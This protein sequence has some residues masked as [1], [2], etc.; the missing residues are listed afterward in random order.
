MTLLAWILVGAALVALLL[1]GLGIV[2]TLR[3]TRRAPFRLPDAELP[4]ISLLK[5]I[6]G[7]EEGLEDNLRSFFDQEYAGER[8]VV[9]ATTELDDPALPIARRV[10]AEF[11]E[12]P[13]RFVLSDPDYGLN[14]KVSNLAGA[15]A[16]ARHDLVL[17]SD[18]NVRAKPDYVRRIVS[19]IVLEG[20]DLLSSM[21]VGVGERSV[22]ATLHNLQLGA[23][24]APGCCF[25]LRYFG[26]AC[27]IGKS[28]LMRKSA[29]SEV[30]GLDSVKD[31]LAEDYVLG[32]MFQKAGKKV[33]L[34]TTTAENVNVDATVDHFMGR[35]A[36]WLKMRACIHVPGFVAD[37]TANATSMLA[38]AAFV[39]SGFAWGTGALLLL[40][41]VLKT[42]GDAYLVKITRGVPMALRHA[43]LAPLRDLVMVAV[44]PYAAVSRSIEWRGTKMRLGWGTRLY[45]DRG[46]LP[47]R[48]MRW[49]LSPLR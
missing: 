11:P 47:V 3:H 8:E 19:E 9:F 27:V 45:P 42:L 26:I 23:F 5:P 20:G 13:T 40:A 18:A 16:A 31:L 48:V 22:G 35:H 25:A 14:P 41:L 24:I 4:P 49:V 43:V 15:L 36:R 46:A 12:I 28:M 37:L 6:K 44:W 34:S 7:V 2:A 33:V 30:G 17:Q 39:A 32:R 1:Y 21:V 10:A 29:L 38:L